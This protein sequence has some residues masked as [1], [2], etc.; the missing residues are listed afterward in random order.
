MDDIFEHSVAPGDPNTR[1][2]FCQAHI[3]PLYAYRTS[4]Y[5]GVTNK[6]WQKTQVDGK[7]TST[8]KANK[9]KNASKSF[10]SKSVEKPQSLQSHNSFFLPRLSNFVHDSRTSSSNMAGHTQ[11][12]IDNLRSKWQAW[13]HFHKKSVQNPELN[14]TGERRS[15]LINKREY[16]HDYGR[17]CCVCENDHQFSLP[18]I[19]AMPSVSNAAKPNSKEAAELHKSSSHLHTSVW[20]SCKMTKYVEA[21]FYNGNK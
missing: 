15:E 16:I 9:L 11:T 10:Y 7:N 17:V 18:Y 13:P 21:S 4:L 2:A 8:K 14:H 12:S 19:T 6:N 3:C 1:P 5:S 20:I